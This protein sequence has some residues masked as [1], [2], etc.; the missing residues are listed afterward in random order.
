MTLAQHA[1]TAPR[2]GTTVDRARGKIKGLALSNRGL[3]SVDAAV[4]R[5]LDR[6][7]ADQGL[8]LAHLGKG[9]RDEGLAAEARV[10]RHDQD[11]VEVVQDP[12]DGLERRRGVQ[13][14]PGLGAGLPDLVEGAV[15]VRA[16]LGVDEG[17]D[18]A[19][20][21]DD[22][23]VDVERQARALPDRLEHGRADRAAKS[24]DRRRTPGSG[25]R[26]M[27]R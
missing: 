25:V 12:F 13:R 7:L 2:A 26:C 5:D 17:L 23:Q 22:H 9:R 3:V 21:L 27:P 11:E 10:D 14:H 8:D 19:L 18:I 20:G 6:P 4:H 24:A 15:Q 1:P 16:G